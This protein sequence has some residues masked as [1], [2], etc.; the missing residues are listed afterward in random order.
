VIDFSSLFNVFFLQGFGFGF[1]ICL[2]LLFFCGRFYNRK[3]VKVNKELSEM[4]V[5]TQT[6]SQSSEQA[7]QLLLQ[8]QQESQDQLEE[9]VQERTLEL[10]IALHELEEVNNELKQKNTLDELTGLFNRRSYDQKILA[11]YRRSKRNLTTLSLVLIDID[12][13][14]V[15]NDT[16]G[17]LAGDQCLVWL[18]EQIKKCLKRSADMAFRYGGEEFCLILPDT[19]SLG[20]IALAEALRKDIAKQPCVYKN[21]ENKVIEISITI[22][23]GISTYSQQQS[24]QPE[25]LF[26][27]ADKALYK[28]KDAGRNQTQFYQ[29]IEE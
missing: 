23:A 10:N 18:G 6:T 9:K 17:H 5:K 24:I 22:S 20:A 28:A 12:Y 7:R 4:L 1:M 11:E 19:D 13:F 3:L 14:K 15:V 2:V 25:Q 16:H 27:N 8:E 26:A 29:Y 21:T